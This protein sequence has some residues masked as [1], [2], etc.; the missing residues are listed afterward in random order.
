MIAI[1]KGDIISSRKID[2]PEVWLLPLKNLFNEWGETPEQWELAWGD[3]FQLEIDSPVEALE[4]AW[5]IKAVIK[6]TGI[7]DVRMSIGIGKKTYAGARISESNGE[8]FIFA[9]EKFE[10]LDKEKSN[11]LIKSPW[12]DFDEEINL[13][14]RLTSL[15]MDTWT[16]AAAELVEMV[17]KEPSLTQTEIGE[18]LGIRQNSVSGR[19][20]RAHVDELLAVDNLYRNKLEKLHL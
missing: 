2:N 9:G 5:L 12:P 7:I 20:K 10:E 14:L 18:R 4:K 17:L 1:I 13:Y 11:L 8:A 19:W 16:V 3:A 15:F 6:K